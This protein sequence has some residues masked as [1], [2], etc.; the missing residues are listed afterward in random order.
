M[1]TLLSSLVKNAQDMQRKVNQYND[2]VE[3]MSLYEQSL[4]EDIIDYGEEQLNLSRWECIDNISSLTEKYW[5]W[6]NEK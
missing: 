2:L 3:K 5:K 4:M 1:T 6:Y